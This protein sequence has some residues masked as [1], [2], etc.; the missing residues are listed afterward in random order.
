[1]KTFTKTKKALLTWVKQVR[2]YKVGK[3]KA[4]FDI[5]YVIDT[6]NPNY[7]E[8]RCD[9]DIYD[10]INEGGSYNPA[11]KLGEKFDKLMDRYEGQYV[12]GGIVRFYK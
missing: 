5:M 9:S 3:E 7:L 6:D 11:P 4:D 10:I 12:G 1:M 2:N 8:F